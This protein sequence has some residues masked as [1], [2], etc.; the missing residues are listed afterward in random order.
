MSAE[1]LQLICPAEH[2]N[3]TLGV[4]HRMF[5]HIFE[6]LEARYSKELAVVRW[7]LMIAFIGIIP[8]VRLITLISFFFSFVC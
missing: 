2:Y 5:R 8:C 4:I 7:A 1:H 3:E 6:G